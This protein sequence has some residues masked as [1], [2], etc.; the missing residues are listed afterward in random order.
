MHRLSLLFAVL[1]VV[2]LLGSDSAK[3]YDDRTEV[4]GIEGT[5]RGTRIDRQYVM[6][7]H[8]GTFTIDDGD[9]NPLRA[10]H[11]AFPSLEASAEASIKTVPSDTRVHCVHPIILHSNS[12]PLPARDNRQF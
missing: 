8:S 4:A 7:Y 12:A 2:P 9:G 1:S 3:E 10:I 5:W 11:K 6:T